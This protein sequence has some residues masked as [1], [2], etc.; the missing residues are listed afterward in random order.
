[1]ST[2]IKST[3][4]FEFVPAQHAYLTVVEFSTKIQRDDNYVRLDLIE[5]MH[6]G[7]FFSSPSSIILMLES[8]RI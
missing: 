5:M 3:S 2:T 4:D 8:R 1:M 7:S 6:A